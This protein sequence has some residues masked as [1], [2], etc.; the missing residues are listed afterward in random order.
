MAKKGT[1]KKDSSGGGRGN[2]GRGGCK[3]PKGGRKG[4]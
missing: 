2:T 4:K 3:N 1:P